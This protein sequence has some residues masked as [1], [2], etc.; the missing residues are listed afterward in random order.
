[1]TKELGAGLD[2]NGVE[3]KEEP[4]DRASA[5]GGTIAIREEAEEKAR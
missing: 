2:E 1:M 3:G 5:E 4:G